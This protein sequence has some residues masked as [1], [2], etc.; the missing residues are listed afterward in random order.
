MDDIRKLEELRNNLKILSNKQRIEYS[1]LEDLYSKLQFE[2]NELNEELA[3][4]N[5]EQCTRLKYVLLSLFGLVISIST[6][7][8]EIEHGDLFLIVFIVI[9]A[10]NTIKYIKNYIEYI[11]KLNK[12]Y[13]L[14]DEQTRITMNAHLING[15]I[16]KLMGKLDNIDEITK[17]NCNIDVNR[18]IER[19]VNDIKSLKLED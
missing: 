19:V 4:I 6:V 10:I 14:E 17:L 12:F 18:C 1:K 15:K 7:H 3:E 16:D 5:E 11:R 13:D 2:M 9:F 8:L